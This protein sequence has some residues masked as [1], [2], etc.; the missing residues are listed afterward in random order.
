MVPVIDMDFLVVSYR[1]VC[2]GEYVCVCVHRCVAAG[3]TCQ[4]VLCSFLSRPQK[5]VAMIVVD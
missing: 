5:L 4:G 3:S 2:E 1:K